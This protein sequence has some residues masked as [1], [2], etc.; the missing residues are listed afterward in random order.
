MFVYRRHII[1][2]ESTNR[3]INDSGEK[4]TNYSITLVVAWPLLD[5]S[6]CIGCGFVVAILFFFFSSLFC[7][8]LW[9]LSIL[10]VCVSRKLNGLASNKIK[11]VPILSYSDSMFSSPYKD[12]KCQLYKQ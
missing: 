8:L 5:T 7:S 4:S 11:S 10:D 6:V 2:P 3:K 1:G 12:E 9:Q